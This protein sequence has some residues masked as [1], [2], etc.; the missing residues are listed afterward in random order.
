VDRRVVHGR[1]VLGREFR[2]LVEPVADLQAG[3]VGDE[4]VRPEA[5]PPSPPGVVARDARIRPCQKIPVACAGMNAPGHERRHGDLRAVEPGVVAGDEA[6]EIALFGLPGGDGLDILARRLRVEQAPHQPVE[7]HVVEPD[8]E[9][10]EL[11]P[12]PE[13]RERGVGAA[14]GLVMDVVPGDDVMDRL[15]GGLRR[16]LRGDG[17]IGCG[18]RR[19]VPEAQR[20]AHR[21]SLFEVEAQRRHTA[22]RPP[23]AEIEISFSFDFRERIGGA[24]ME[25]RHAGRRVRGDHQRRRG[26]LRCQRARRR[27]IAQPRALRSLDA[28]QHPV[29]QAPFAAARQRPAH[30]GGVRREVVTPVERRAGVVGREAQ[31]RAV[32]R[33]G[34]EAQL[35]AGRQRPGALQ[36]GREQRRRHA[37]AAFQMHERGGA[38][39]VPCPPAVPP[40][41]ALQTPSSSA[42]SQISICASKRG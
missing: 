15:Q 17:R 32:E 22:F 12:V 39:D 5:A 26:A 21:R 42:L 11:A 3:A 36:P 18:G 31:P 1:L 19:G 10:A 33:A 16:S 29:A 35:R 25:G 30:R 6:G 37:P 28:E 8:A 4:A 7:Q 41:D 13:P 40:H 2:A 14:V 27:I 24:V 9:A 20:H 38:F 23:R 34:A